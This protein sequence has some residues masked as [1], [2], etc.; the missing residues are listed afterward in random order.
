[1][2]KIR[3]NSI[4]IKKG[5]NKQQKLNI[6]TNRTK[7][8]PNEIHKKAQKTKHPL[9]KNRWHLPKI[10]RILSATKTRNN[11]AQKRTRIRTREERITRWNKSFEMEIRR[12]EDGK[13]R[14]IKWNRGDV[15][16]DQ[17]EYQGYWY[18]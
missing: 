18:S 2:L 10:A 14:E 11:K 5:N 15:K 6:K 16:G 17:W 1:M 12:R 13:Y 4:R 8:R 3:N 7:R 9:N